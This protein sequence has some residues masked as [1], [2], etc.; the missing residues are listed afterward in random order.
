MNCGGGGSCGTCIVEVNNSF[1]STMFASKTYRG[2]AFLVFTNSEVLQKVIN[3]FY[4][5]AQRGRIMQKVPG[6]SCLPRLLKGIIIFFSLFGP[7]I[8]VVTIHLIDVLLVLSF[9][10]SYKHIAFSLSDHR[11]KGSPK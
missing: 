3:R 5:L 6:V 10:S 8:T 9:S 4:Y 11:W 1:V 2:I 7:R